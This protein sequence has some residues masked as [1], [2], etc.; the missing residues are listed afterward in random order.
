MYFSS[1]KDSSANFVIENN[2][3][4]KVF[5]WRAMVG[6]KEISRGIANLK[7]DEKK[8]FILDDPRL[9]DGKIIIEVYSGDEETRKIYKNL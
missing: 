3:D 9:K 6:K 1:A 2:G 4:A 8:D 7:Q 5:N